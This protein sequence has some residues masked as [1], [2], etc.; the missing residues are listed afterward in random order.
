MEKN[1]KVVILTI[2]TILLLASAFV[3]FFNESRGNTSQYFN[4]L[5]LASDAKLYLSPSTIIKQGVTPP[6]TLYLNISVFNITNMASCE[7]NITFTPNIVIPKSYKVY[8][9]QGQYPTADTDQSSKKGYFWAKLTYGTAISLPNANASLLNIGFTAYY[10]ST[11]LH[12]VEAVLKDPNGNTISCTT[13]DGSVWI[14]KH[15]VAVTNVSTSTNETYVGRIVN[16]TVTT[17]NLGNIAE[18]YYINVSAGASLLTQFQ[19]LNMQPNEIRTLTFNWNTS[20][21]APSMTPYTIKAQAQ[22]LP[23]ETNTANNL[24]VDGQ[25]KLK[26]VGDVNGDGKVDINDL[27]AWDAAYGSTPGSSNWNPQADINGDGIVDKQDGILI[28]QNYQNHL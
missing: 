1:K 20:S 13:Q 27:K 17:Q 9:V 22:I 21:W 15:D 5:A 23:Y 25:V 3:A 26:L 19:V 18:N 28:I 16:I 24:Y 7:F 14:I 4:N 6:V 10:G 2:I 8:P 12:F 11:T